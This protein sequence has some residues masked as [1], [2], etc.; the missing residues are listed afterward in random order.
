MKKFLFAL[1]SICVAA[2]VS[3]QNS[4]LLT[5]LHELRWE[6]RILVVNEP[7]APQELIVRLQDNAEA[8]N[9]RR[10]AWFMI[11][12]NELRSNYV[13]PVANELR[14]NIL[15]R[16]DPAVNDVIL[17]GLDGGV[18]ARGDEIDLE[19]LYG[20]IDAMPMRRSELRK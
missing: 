9:E 13:G 18:K 12:G 15:L 17:M 10:L 8:L 14:N 1:L 3:A 20:T 4:D 5:D 2:T 19:A 6:Y 7:E 11:S 16:L